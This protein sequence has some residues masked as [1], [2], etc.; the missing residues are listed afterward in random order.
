MTELAE[1]SSGKITD[2]LVNL[3][4]LREDDPAFTQTAS[5]IPEMPTFHRL[6]GVCE[7]HFRQTGFWLVSQD[8][9]FCALRLTDKFE[10]PL[11]CALQFGDLREDA[12]RK[13][14]LELVPWNID[15]YD[16]PTAVLRLFFDRQTRLNGLVMTSKA[17]LFSPPVRGTKQQRLRN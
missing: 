9:T 12:L 15:T 10:G 17:R 5:L 2:A 13:M 6:D 1:F 4:G 7:V 14:R 3:L 8:A 16:L 11:P